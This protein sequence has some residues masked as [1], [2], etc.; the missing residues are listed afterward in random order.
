MPPDGPA[1]QIFLFASVQNFSL[2]E[3]SE[4]LKNVFIRPKD[5]R[6]GIRHRLIPLLPQS[7]QER[8]VAQE[9]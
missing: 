3:P 4:I 5:F 6:E 8:G 2:E 1:K 9:Q 7:H